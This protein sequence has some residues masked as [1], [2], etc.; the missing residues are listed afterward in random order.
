MTTESSKELPAPIDLSHYFS[1][2][3]KNKAASPFKA[4]YKFFQ[5]PGIGNF[6]GGRLL[7]DMGM[8]G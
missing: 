1:E 6:A 4:F 5:I 2:T 3:A 8:P 7:L